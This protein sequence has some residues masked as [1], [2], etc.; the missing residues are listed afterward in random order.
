M[1]SLLS[2]MGCLPCAPQLAA[3]DQSPHKP[4]S[5]FS[6]L[7]LHIITLSIMTVGDTST[8]LAW[9]LAAESE[10]DGTQHVFV[11]KHVAAHLGTRIQLSHTTRI[12]F[13]R[14]SFVCSR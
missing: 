7:S 9:I 13:S 11:L 8:T 14:I 4:R 6:Q 1:E 2:T 5:G 10:G 3:R 12:S